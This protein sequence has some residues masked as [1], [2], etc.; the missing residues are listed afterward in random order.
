MNR[1]ERKETEAEKE[2]DR[3]QRPRASREGERE[4]EKNRESQKEIDADGVS[5]FCHTR[6]Q[7]QSLHVAHW[8]GTWRSGC[9][10]ASD[11]CQLY[12]Y[13]IYIMMW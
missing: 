10:A 8:A 4:R 3:R 2:G 1:K 7:H 5:I 9:P 11:R 6:M 12:I 13:I